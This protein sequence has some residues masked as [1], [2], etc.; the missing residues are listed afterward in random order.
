MQKAD[1][2]REKKFA[3]ENAFLREVGASLS[4]STSIRSWD[5]PWDDPS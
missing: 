2:I 1:L 3:M 5:D 4:G